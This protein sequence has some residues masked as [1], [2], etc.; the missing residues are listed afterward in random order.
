MISKLSLEISILRLRE[1]RSYFKVVVC[2]ELGKNGSLKADAAKED[3][4]YSRVESSLLLS[5]S[6]SMK[7][8]CKDRN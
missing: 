1:L 2:F 6:L 5:S 3:K 8:Y 4:W 7:W